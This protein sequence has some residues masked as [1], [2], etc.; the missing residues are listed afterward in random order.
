MRQTY[1]LL[2]TV[3]FDGVFTHDY[4]TGPEPEHVI[5]EK[6]YRLLVYVK[7]VSAE[8]AEYLFGSRIP[9]KTQIPCRGMVKLTLRNIECF[10]AYRSN[11]YV[12]LRVKR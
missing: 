6:N 8:S 1:V 12:C 4:K 3:P 5:V 11:R 10:L 7:K 2:T 9:D